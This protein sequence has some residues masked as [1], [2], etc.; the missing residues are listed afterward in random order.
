MNWPHIHLM[1]NH[2]PIVGAGIALAAVVWGWVAKSRAV[3]LFAF[4]LTAAI[5]LATYPVMLTGHEAE[6]AVEDL[7][8]AQR[9]IIHE[10]EEMGEKANIA[11]VTTGV[12][13]LLALW[14]GRGGRE[15]RAGMTGV[16]VLALVVGLVLVALT[17]LDGGEIR[18]DEIRDGP[19][20]ETG[21]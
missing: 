10:H 16:V 1:V 7:P 15:F 21:S 4:T 8:W 19:V 14:L 5:G 9:R 11:M 3:L 20:A 13:A 17:A 18:H 12:L 6:E 2:I